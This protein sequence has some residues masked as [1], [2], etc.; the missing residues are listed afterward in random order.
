MLSLPPIINSEHS[1]ISLNT[2]N[3]LVEVTATDQ[4]KAEIVLNT[5]LC[6]FSAYCDNQYEIE[7]VEVT[8]SDGSKHLWPQ[9]DEREMTASVK[10][11]N[12]CI[13]VNLEREHMATILKKV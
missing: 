4:T 11:I 2:R 12:E 6:L 8:N 10:Y 9:L 5:I 13:G 3:L 7:Q 1:K